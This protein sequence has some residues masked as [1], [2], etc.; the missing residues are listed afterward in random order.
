MVANRWNGWKPD[1][2]SGAAAQEGQAETPSPKGPTPSPE[3]PPST[4]GRSEPDADG[5][6]RTRSGW[7]KLLPDMLKGRERDEPR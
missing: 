3:E 6:V 1:L 2:G 7:R 4:T 5:V